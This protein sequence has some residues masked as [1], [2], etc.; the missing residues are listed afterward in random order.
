MLSRIKRLAVTESCG[1]PIALQLATPGQ[2]HTLVFL[3]FSLSP[4]LSNFRRQ[5]PQLVNHRLP[6]QRGMGRLHRLMQRQ[7]GQIAPLPACPLPELIKRLFTL[8]ADL[9]DLLAVL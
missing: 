5:A 2:R 8:G 9:E 3:R 6:A 4:G 7:P 1:H